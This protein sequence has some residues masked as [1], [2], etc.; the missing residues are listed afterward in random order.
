[1]AQMVG[2]EMGRKTR[3]SL[4]TVAPLPA[5]KLIRKVIPRRDEAGSH[6]A[7]A[8]P[9]PPARDRSYWFQSKRE[10]VREMCL[11]RSSSPIWNYVDRNKF[12]EFTATPGGPPLLQSQYLGGIYVALT[13]F[14]YEAF[15]E[16]PAAS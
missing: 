14:C 11:D 16:V 10:Q 3:R 2:N 4:R 6:A 12:D 8:A 15:N 13:L 1:M 5:R 7:S 9:P